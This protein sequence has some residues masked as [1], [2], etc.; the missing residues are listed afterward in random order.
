MDAN[1]R[2]PKPLKN[3]TCSLDPSLDTRQ[4]T[5]DITTLQNLFDLRHDCSEFGSDCE[6][7]RKLAKQ[8]ASKHYKL[9]S[10]W[11][12][13][14]REKP[15]TLSSRL[16][17]FDQTPGAK[18]SYL[19]YMNGKIVYSKPDHPYYKKNPSTQIRDP[20]CNELKQVVNKIC[21]KDGENDIAKKVK[22]NEFSVGMVCGMGTTWHPSLQTCE[23]VPKEISDVDGTGQPY[24]A[25]IY[26]A[27]RSNNYTTPFDDPTREFASANITFRASAR[28]FGT[29]CGCNAERCRYP[30]TS[31]EGRK[32]A[33]IFVKL[34]REIYEN[35]NCEQTTPQCNLRYKI[36]RIIEL[37]Q[38]NFNQGLH[39]GNHR[40]LP[41][42]RWYLLEME[43]ILIE[44]QKELNPA[45]IR[46]DDRF[47]GIPYFDWHNLKI[48]ETPM[49][50]VNDA[51][52]LYGHHLHDSFGQNTTPHSCFG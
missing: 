50:F 27:I 47:L 26:P 7:K 3:G 45:T 41:W 35:P 33:R 18:D 30:L 48:G 4:C 10:K 42:H 11:K 32:Q 39:G 16:I 31:E 36:R 37:H 51:S 8:Q 21:K 19:D 2:S 23:K 5:K 40:F 13:K 25:S 28:Q 29:T 14:D 44:G 24:E 52:D 9:K 1:I 34:F 22:T 6:C 15:D 38:E 46:C 49:T 17:S 43:T 12:R 20:S